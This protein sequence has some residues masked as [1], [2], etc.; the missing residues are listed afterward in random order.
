MKHNFA[1][2]ISVFA[3]IFSIGSFVYQFKNNPLGKGVNNYSFDSPLESYKS[4][5]KMA[6]NNDFLAIIEL[7]NIF[8]GQKVKEEIDTIEVK[9]KREY[10]G[11]TFM[12][13]TLKK[14][15]IPI[16]KVVIMEKDASSGYWKHHPYFSLYGL[17]SDEGK[18]LNKEIKQ[19]K[20]N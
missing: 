6:L 9:K 11:K 15:D 12:F 10:D 20:K 17:T 3:V 16:Q 5:L 1:I 14:S 19:W 13:V 18:T 8:E 4:K 7:I 2:I